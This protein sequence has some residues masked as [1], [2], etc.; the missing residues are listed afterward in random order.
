MAE[1]IDGDLTDCGCAGCDDRLHKDVE[2]QVQ[3]GDIIE[4]EAR[5]MHTQI[6]LRKVVK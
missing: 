1:F 3:A 6:D 5:E 4:D 2:R